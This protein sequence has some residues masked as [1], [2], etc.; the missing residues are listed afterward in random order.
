MNTIKNLHLLEGI[1]EQD[2][3]LMEQAA[4]LHRRYSSIFFK[5]LEFTPD[6]VV[7]RVTQ[8]KSAA[9]NYQNQK[10][11]AEIVHETFDRFFPGR[12]V[13]ARPYPYKPAAPEQVD[14][15]WI[16]KK[17]SAAG[18]TL[19]Q[20]SEETGLNYPNLS[21]ITSSDEEEISPVMKALFYYYFTAKELQGQK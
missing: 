6:S 20:V 2:L 10:R 5:I 7:I 8:E 12:S 14:Q 15:K 9:E 19:K 1:S 3:A 4:V 16:A 17:M 11:L 13:H 18:L 21:K